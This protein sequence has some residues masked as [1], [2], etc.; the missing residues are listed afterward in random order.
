MILLVRLREGL[1]GERERVV[2]VVPVPE[3]DAVP[4]ALT[5]FCGERIAPGSAE[6]L[7]GPAGMPCV[8]C[9]VRMPPPSSVELPPGG[10]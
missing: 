10:G 4:D 5:A 6:L 8:P 9:L 7:P 1:R 3:P 2:H